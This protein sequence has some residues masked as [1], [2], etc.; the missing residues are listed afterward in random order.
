MN[1][2]RTMRD[3]EDAFLALEA[4][5]A[6][7]RLIYKCNRNCVVLLQDRKLKAALKQAV[8]LCKFKLKRE[9]ARDFSL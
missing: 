7:S 2:M 5:H 3:R 8:L 1:D 6:R 9:K 4:S